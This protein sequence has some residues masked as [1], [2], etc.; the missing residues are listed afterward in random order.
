MNKHGFTLLCGCH[1]KIV[2]TH[3]LMQMQDG[4]PVFEEELQVIPCHD[5]EDDPTSAFRKDSV[6]D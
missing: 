6:D 1:V 4:T 2:D 3:V 5:H